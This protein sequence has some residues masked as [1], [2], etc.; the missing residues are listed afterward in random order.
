MDTVRNMIQAAVLVNAL[1]TIAVL[2]KL[3]E[4]PSFDYRLTTGLIAGAYILLHIF[5]PTP[6]FRHV[7]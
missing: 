2:F 5:R 1:V 6:R 3:V 4:L 7:A